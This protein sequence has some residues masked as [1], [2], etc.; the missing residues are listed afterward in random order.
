[1]ERVCYKGILAELEAR[2][3]S[4]SL[5]MVPENT[6]EDRWGDPMEQFVFHVGEATRFAFPP[7]EL[8]RGM[9]LTIGHNGIA[10]RS[11]PPQ[12]NALFVLC[13]NEPARA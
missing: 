5:V 6:P 9:T 4:L 3:D 2:P 7:E 8:R 10:T 12:G 13:T 1:M 11:L